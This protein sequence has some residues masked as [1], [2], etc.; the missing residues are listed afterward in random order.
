MLHSLRRTPVSTP[1]PRPC[2]ACAPKSAGSQRSHPRRGPPAPPSSP[3]PGTRNLRA[4]GGGRA[5]LGRSGEAL[6]AAGPQGGLGGRRGAGLG[7]ATLT[8][9]GY[10]SARRAGP[11][12][13]H[14]AARLAAS[15]RPAAHARR[16]R[17]RGRQGAAGRR[18]PRPR[19]GRG[20]RPAEYQPHLPQCSWSGGGFRFQRFRQSPRRHLPSLPPGRPRSGGRGPVAP[21]RRRGFWGWGGDWLG[22]AARPPGAGVLGSRGCSFGVTSC[23]QKVEHN[24]RKPTR[25]NAPPTRGTIPTPLPFFIPS[26]P[27]SSSCPFLLPPL[28][29]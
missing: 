28:S 13:E 16:G 27:A 25:R 15:L 3:A 11:V 7:R 26:S 10:C 4:S 29:L 14:K 23:F 20:C 18:A 2:P 21:T 24:I 12:P 6:A 5:A 9:P 19:L 22:S 8:A 17:H 1:R